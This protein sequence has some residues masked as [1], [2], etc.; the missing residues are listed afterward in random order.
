M[1]ERSSAPTAA[2]APAKIEPPVA[3]KTE[4]EAPVDDGFEAVVR[5]DAKPGGKKFQGVW[6]ERADGERWVVAYRPEAWL[7]VFEDQK[8][9]VIGE[10]Y[11][12]PGQRISATH[13]R[14]TT[15]RTVERGRG[16]LLAVGP[17]QTFTGNFKRVAGGAG[18]KSEG[19]SWWT[20]VAADGATHEIE[21]T[22]EKAEIVEGKAVTITARRV[23]P[24]M[25]YTARRGAESWLWVVRVDPQ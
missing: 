3:Q 12:P 9:R 21:G 13:F 14:I 25:S 19:S 10:T 4:A 24:D 16:P 11:E 20:F 1:T 5:V 7:R 18:T 8:V 15:L 6:L 17:E 22:P 2:P 23:E